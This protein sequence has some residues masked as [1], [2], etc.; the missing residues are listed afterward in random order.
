MGITAYKL[1]LICVNSDAIITWKQN[2]RIEMGEWNYQDTSAPK[3]TDDFKK[4]YFVEIKKKEAVK[5]VGLLVLGHEKGIKNLT[6]EVLQFPNKDNGGVCIVQ[7][8]LIGY[9]WSPADKKIVEAN[10]SAI[11]DASRENC[12]SMVADSFIR[13]AETRA[14][15]RVLRNYT[16]IGML[17]SD[18]VGSATE[19]IVP[20]INPNQ[21]NM[22]WTLM[23]KYGVEKEQAREITFN[24]CGKSDA[25]SLT[26]E[27]AN[28]VIN[29]MKKFIAANQK[30]Q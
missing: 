30:K 17:C 10:F 16:N 13:M 22:I 20:L 24:T 26:E 9:A 5:A 23:K 14:V 18:E 29:A 19:D 15:G 1:Y 28:H 7:A 11:G 4:N 12:S 2:R 27:E 6:T 3:V 21:I 25:R 8:N